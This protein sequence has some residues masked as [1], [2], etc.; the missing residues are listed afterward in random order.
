V[1]WILLILLFL[2]VAGAVLAFGPTFT[3]PILGPMA[4]REPQHVNFALRFQQRVAR[5]LIV[6]LA[7]F[8]GVTGL[9]LI[10]RVA[11]IQDVSFI[12][13]LARGWLLTAI[14]LYVIALALTFGI[15]LPTLRTLIEATSAPPPPPPPSGDAPHG[16]PP[17]IAALVQRGRMVG[18]IQSALILAIIFLMVTKPF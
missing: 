6:P 3:F 8:Q 7:L 9:L 15:G 13:V 12:D 14:V 5:T 16:P 2:H 18:M 11:D 10:F 4:G 1:D 17:H